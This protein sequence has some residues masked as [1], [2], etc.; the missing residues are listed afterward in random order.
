MHEKGNT[1]RPSGIYPRCARG[2]QHKKS[3][4]VI[5]S[6]N[7]LKKKPT[8]SSQQIQLSNK[9]QHS[10]VMKTFQKLEIKANFLNLI[11]STDEKLTIHETA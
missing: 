9:I 4:N 3:I 8:R 7:R 5:H 2:I 11:K 10:L 1:S 6:I